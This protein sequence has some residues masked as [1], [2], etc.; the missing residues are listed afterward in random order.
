MKN[1]EVYNALTRFGNLANYG[2]TQYDVNALVKFLQRDMNAPCSRNNMALYGFSADQIARLDS[3]VKLVT[4]RIDVST[5]EA[6]QKHLAK[7]QGRTTKTNVR[8]FNQ[9]RNITMYGWIHDVPYEPWKLL[10]GLKGEGLVCE[11]LKM[12][13]DWYEVKCPQVI[14]VRRGESMTAKDVGTILGAEK[15]TKK[16]IL[17]LKA[18]FVEVLPCYYFYQATSV[19]TTVDSY[20]CL[21]R[22]GDRY[23]VTY[24]KLKE[25]GKLTASRADTTIGFTYGDDKLSE[26]LY[27][28]AVLSC[29]MREPGEGPKNALEELKALKYEGT[30]SEE[31]MQELVNLV[32][33][34]EWKQS[35]ALAGVINIKFIPAGQTSDSFDF[36]DFGGFGDGF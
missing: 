35:G 33:G 19:P 13:K 26:S 8:N 25:N 30:T 34:E 6:L 10:N 1:Y 14:V 18:D 36:G 24:D 9:E 17:R 22:S 21:L 2:F 4:Q 20:L 28:Y 16:M 29:L 11:I 27:K 31:R 12:S 5:D 3:L 23:Y 15:E 7:L 32:Q